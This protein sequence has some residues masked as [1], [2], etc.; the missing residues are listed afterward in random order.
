VQ[1]SARRTQRRRIHSGTAAA[2]PRQATSAV[3]TSARLVPDQ[4]RPGGEFVA[5]WAMS[6]RL[7]YPT[8]PGLDELTDVRLSGHSEIVMPTVDTTTS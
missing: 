2:R 3:R 1:Y 8:L 7:D 6:R 4:E 5:V